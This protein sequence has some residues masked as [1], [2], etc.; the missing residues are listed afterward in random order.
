M[1]PLPPKQTSNIS[2]FL[3]FPG[4]CSLATP[5]STFLYI[6]PSFKSFFSSRYA[7][8]NRLESALNDVRFR[9][10]FRR[11]RGDGTLGL[12]SHR[13]GYSYKIGLAV[14][15]LFTQHSGTRVCSGSMLRAKHFHT[16]IAP[17]LLC[18]IILSSN[19]GS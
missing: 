6:S 16:I 19:G 13:Y 15:H 11:S 18:K 4:L 3:L 14:L 10:S 2:F 7:T 9:T 12:C 5:A 8:E 17:K 1:Q